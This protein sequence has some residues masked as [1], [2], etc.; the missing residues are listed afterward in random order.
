MRKLVTKDWVHVS[1]R[2]VSRVEG[3]EGPLNLHVFFGGLFLGGLN[4]EK[5]GDNQRRKFFLNS[6]EIYQGL[7]RL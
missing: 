7:G 3:S 4:A 6:S 2:L 1:S 5:C